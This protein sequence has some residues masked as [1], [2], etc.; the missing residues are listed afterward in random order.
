MLLHRVHTQV[1]GSG[2]FFAALAFRYPV[3]N[4]H[5]TRTKR[6]KAGFDPVGCRC[7]HTLVS[8][9]QSW[10]A[11]RQ[12]STVFLRKVTPFFYGAFPVFYRNAFR[13]KP[14]APVNEL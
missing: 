10:Y 9:P 11:K 7:V 6:R 13:K 3:K 5:F 14:V 4:L 12:K 2:N 1:Q 8:I